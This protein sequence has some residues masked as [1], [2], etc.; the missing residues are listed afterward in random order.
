MSIRHGPFD[1]VVV[2][3]AM[4]FDYGLQERARHQHLAE[5]RRALQLDQRRQRL[6]APEEAVLRPPPL[7]HV[8]ALLGRVAARNGTAGRG[9]AAPFPPPSPV[10]G[11]SA[12]R[13][14]DAPRKSCGR[15]PFPRTAPPRAGRPRSRRRRPAAAPTRRSGPP[16]RASRRGTPAPAAPA[17]APCSRPGRASAVPKRGSSQDSLSCRANS[18]NVANRHA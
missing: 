16:H 18:S 6:L 3:V 5:L 2:V 4:R 12:S 15:R 14:P 9:A 8:L 17:R 7:R 13:R 1:D 11:G 10:R